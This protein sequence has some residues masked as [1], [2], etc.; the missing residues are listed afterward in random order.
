MGIMT[1]DEALAK[2]RETN[3]DLIEIAPKAN[4]PVAKII[5]FGKFRYREE[6]KARAEAK[7]TK[8]D[9]KEVR[10]SPF[11]GEADYNT[12]LA[13]VKEFLGDGDK[14]KLAVVFKGSQMG[15]KQFGYE[16]LNKV[17]GSLGEGIS[18][19]MEPKFFGRNLITVIS[20]RKKG[21]INA[22]TKNKEVNNQEIQN[23]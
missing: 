6:K 12:R 22:E 15:R 2:A 8:S 9:L 4:P 1:R 11:I 13:R 10:L 19:D 14:V 5:E 21:A 17:T 23:N 3:E 7:K 18:I 20:P 16:L